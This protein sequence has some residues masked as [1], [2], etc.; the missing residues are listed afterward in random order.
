MSVESLHILYYF[1][2]GQIFEIKRNVDNPHHYTIVHSEN[3]FQ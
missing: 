3:A 1:Y 2:F